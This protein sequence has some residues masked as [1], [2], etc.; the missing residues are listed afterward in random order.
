MQQISLQEC[1]AP[2]ICRAAKLS[3]MAGDDDRQ[4]IIDLCAYTGMS[5]SMV[6]KK[7]ELSPS[8]LTRPLQEPWKFRLSAPTLDKLRVAF[9]DFPRFKLLPDLPI[10]AE[11]RDYV[12]IDVLPTYAGMGGG[13]TGEGDQEQALVPR[14]LIEG[15]LRGRQGDFLL[16][17]VRGDS[18]EPDFRHDD[19]LLVDT[20]DKSPAQPGPFALWH[21]EEYVVKNVEKMLNGTVR[22]FSTNLKYSAV[23]QPNES[24]KIIGR[25]VWFGRRL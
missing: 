4:L 8:T 13:G 7:A 20:R 9:P 16:V 22:I 24:T 5:A 10:A 17:R 21:D 25:P 3:A 15:I 18:M 23:D 11:G 6:A 1:N 2:S 12:A 14:Y 19:E